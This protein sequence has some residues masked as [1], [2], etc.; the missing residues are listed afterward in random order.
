MRWSF[1]LIL[2]GVMVAG[3]KSQAPTTDPFF[4][5]TTIPPP[6]TGSSTG[7]PSS[8]AYQ[9]P[10]LLP[11][12]T[13]TPTGVAPPQVQLPAQPT[14]SSAN[15]QPSLP[16]QPLAAQPSAPATRTAPAATSRYLA[17]RPSSTAPASATAPPTSSIA[18]PSTSPAI[19]SSTIAPPSLSP[20]AA[21][22]VRGTTTYTPPNSSYNCAGSTAPGPGPS[23]AAQPDARMPGPVV[24]GVAAT[25]VNIPGE[26]RMPRP[27]DNATTG[28]SPAVRQPITRTIEP[29]PKDDASSRPIDITDLPTR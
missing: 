3:C 2:V 6:S 5:R 25:R 20:S 11:P 24:T 19:P 27:V 15:T 22:P 4:G 10:P 8:Q 1:A 16:A 13:Q 14:A 7:Q 12:S 17:P 9:P 23:T 18:P 21:V 28:N 29:R 26:D